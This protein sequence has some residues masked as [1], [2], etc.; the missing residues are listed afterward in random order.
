MN[1]KVLA[2]LEFNVILNEAQATTQTGNELL[3]KYKAF[4]MANEVSC[5][6][7]NNFVKEAT[8]HRYDNGINQ[9]LEDVSD[10]ITMNKTVWALASACESINNN[11]HSYNYLNRNAC[12]QVE[13]LLEMEEEDVVKYV[14]AGALKNVMY[15]ES[16]RN[17]AKQ[18]YKDQPMV[19]HTAEYSKTTPVSMVENVGDGF[20]FEICGTLYKIDE[21]NNVQEAQVSEDNQSRFCPNCGAKIEGDSKFCASCGKEI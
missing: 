5:G 7:V 3:K 8:A 18:V 1:N 12:K 6:L 9:V 17:I 16:F 21:D 10:Y 15:C 19:E 2:E 13:K 11:N 20:C 14:K 4:C